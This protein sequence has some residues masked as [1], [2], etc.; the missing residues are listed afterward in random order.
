M[1][2]SMEQEYVN[3][4]YKLLKACDDVSDA[5]ANLSPENLKRFKLEFREIMP[6]A[7]INLFNVLND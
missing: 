2:E 5:V 1:N 7:V 6:T 3:F 4:K